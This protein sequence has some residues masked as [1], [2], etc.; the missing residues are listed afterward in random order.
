M[1]YLVGIIMR[2]L[3]SSHC[4]VVSLNITETQVS[5]SILLRL[6]VFATLVMPSKLLLIYRTPLRLPDCK[7][8]F[9]SSDILCSYSSCLQ[10]RLNCIDLPS[11]LG[12]GVAR[13][14]R[15]YT[16]TWP[17]ALAVFILM[18]NRTISTN[19]SV[20]SVRHGTDLLIESVKLTYFYKKYQV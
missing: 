13:C 20:K 15:S 16:N 11:A 12:N 19:D 7:R 6:L 2:S 17:G 8:Y 18:S 4:I 3:E 14:G 5:F 9:K 1:L 10:W